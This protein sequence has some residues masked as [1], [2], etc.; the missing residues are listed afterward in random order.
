VASLGAFV[1][2]GDRLLLWQFTVIYFVICSASVACWAYTGAM[3]SGVL[4]QARNVQRFNRS[5]A[6]L[7]VASACYLLADGV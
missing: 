3:L 1:A 7:L 6:L 5:M 4:Q 2:D